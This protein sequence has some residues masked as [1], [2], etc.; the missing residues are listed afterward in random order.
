MSAFCC[1]C[2]ICF[3]KFVY[4]TDA[5]TWKG[6]CLLHAGI[7]LNT[8][9][10]ARLLKGANKSVKRNS[11][12][13]IPHELLPLHSPPRRRL[14]QSAS[15]RSPHRSASI[16]SKQPQN[17]TETLSS[18]LFL[19]DSSSNSHLKHLAFKLYEI[20]GCNRSSCSYSI[21][22]SAGCVIVLI[23]HTSSLTKLIVRAESFRIQPQDVSALVP[24]Y[25]SFGV[26]CRYSIPLSK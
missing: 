20:T 16:S 4:F 15:R 14:L 18:S 5:Y 10:I 23:G 19:K 24:I 2:L 3:L 12:S 8:I 13:D 22:L 17:G 25:I 7:L 21:M 6:A 1:R 9:A 11:L 26:V